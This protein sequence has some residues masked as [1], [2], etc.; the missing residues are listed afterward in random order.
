MAKKKSNSLSLSLSLQ[1]DVICYVENP[2]DS[3][4]KLLELIQEFSKVAGY[5]INAHKSVA[6]LYANNKTEGREIKESLPFTIAPKSIRYLGINITKEIKDLCCRNYRTHMKEIEEDTKKWK[7]RS[8]LMDW[9][10]K[11]CENVYAT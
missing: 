5:Q 11:S 8:M 7:K 4:P 2:K 10:K 6:F 9:K 1:N 3:T